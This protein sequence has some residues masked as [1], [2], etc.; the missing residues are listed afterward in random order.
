METLTQ[1]I[2]SHFKRCLPSLPINL[3]VLWEPLIVDL[4]VI[5][6][7]LEPEVSKLGWKSW[8]DLY[9]EQAMVVTCQ[10]QSS[11]APK[12]MMLWN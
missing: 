10:S 6:F 5:L 3:T 2:Q 7:Y 11:Y 9:Q 1:F 12:Q 8:L 4:L